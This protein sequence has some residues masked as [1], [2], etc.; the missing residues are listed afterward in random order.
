[1]NIHEINDLINSLD[2][3]RY[4]REEI[5]VEGGGEETEEVLYLDGIE[6][7]LTALLNT[8]GVDSLGR[9]YKAQE[10]RKKTLKAEKDYITR[11]MAAIDN[12]LDYIKAK[13]D[14]I[15]AA[16]GCEKVKGILGYS[17]ARA[18]STTTTVDKDILRDHF[19]AIV[20]DAV[21][22]L[23]P[24]DVTVSLSASVSKLEDGAELPD[25]YTRTETPT[26]RVTKPRANKEA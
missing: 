12:T 15:M 4:K 13:I 18:V 2:Y 9:W 6:Q 11:Q 20:E 26:V 19:Q 23:R 16:T 14:E 5:L 17:F 24:A 21:K 25:Y 8:D 1:M 10:D 7:S 22:D 3:A